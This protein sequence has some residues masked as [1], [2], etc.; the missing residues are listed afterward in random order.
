M[1]TGELLGCLKLIP[2]AQICPISVNCIHVEFDQTHALHHDYNMI[3][4]RKEECS[5]SD[6]YGERRFVA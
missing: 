5:F 1:Q 2:H 3:F 4:G 6:V